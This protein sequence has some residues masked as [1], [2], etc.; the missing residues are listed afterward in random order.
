LNTENHQIINIARS[1]RNFEDLIKKY[2]QFRQYPKL[3]KEQNLIEFLKLKPISIL[4]LKDSYKVKVLKDRIGHH[5][6]LTPSAKLFYADEP[7]SNILKGSNLLGIFP[8]TYYQDP[9]RFVE[10]ELDTLEQTIKFDINGTGLNEFDQLGLSLILDEVTAE[11]EMIFIDRSER[12]YYLSK[13]NRLHDLETEEVL[14]LK[15]DP[16][17]QAEPD[18]LIP[19]KVSSRRVL[20]DKNLKVST[21]SSKPS[22]VIR[23]MHAEANLD[24]D[25]L[26]QFAKQ[27]KPVLDKT[28]YTQKDLLLAIELLKVELPLEDVY[29][30]LNLGSKVNQ[31]LLKLNS[32]KK[33]TEHEIYK[34]VL[35]D[36]QNN[37]DSAAEKFQDAL[38]A[39]FIKKPQLKAKFDDIQK[40]NLVEGLATFNLPTVVSGKTSSVLK[41]LGTYREYKVFSELDSKFIYNKPAGED[42]YE[43]L[44]LSKLASCWRANGQ[45]ISEGDLLLSFDH[46]LNNN[47]LK[48]QVHKDRPSRALDDKSMPGGKYRTELLTKDSCPIGQVQSWS[49]YIKLEDQLYNPIFMQAGSIDNEFNKPEFIVAATTKGTFSFLSRKQNGDEIINTKAEFGHYSAK[50]WTKLSFEFYWSASP[51]GSIKIYQ[52]DIEV[53]KHEGP[54]CF[55]QAEALRYV[56]GLYNVDGVL[57]DYSRKGKGMRTKNNAPELIELMIGKLTRKTGTIFKER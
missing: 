4:H 22:K 41:D 3:L 44:K 50:V 35:A 42:L 14:S 47:I 33:L 38:E 37:Y 21:L 31:T 34:L 2:P 43:D 26:I 17:F 53:F 49:F 27:C 8:E 16:R 48:F 10:L 45:G 24:K 13:E 6:Y 54:N 9:K 11:S 1:A 51:S 57:R 36:Y 15:L 32:L 28:Y 20:Y 23:V 25:L 46:E 18:N 29:Q 12:K 39:V 56:F 7:D 52:D 5:Y 40:I 55:E 19:I 30:V